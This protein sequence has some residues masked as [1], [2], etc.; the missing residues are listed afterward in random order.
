MRFCLRV[1]KLLH[2][3]FRRLE[4][5]LSGSV[6]SAVTAKLTKTVSRSPK[7]A[8]KRDAIIRAA[9]EIINEKSF[10]LATMT[11]IAGSLGMRDAAL[12]YYFSD[13]QTLVFACHIR[14][15][16]RFEALLDGVAQSS[17][18]GLAKLRRFIKRMLADS[19]KNG[20]QLYFGDH[21]YLDTAKRQAID[22]WAK[23]LTS[24]LEQFII[25]GIEDGSVVSCETAMVVQLLL[26]TLIWLAKWV[27]AD[28]TVDRL[29]TAILAFSFHGL[30]SRSEAR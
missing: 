21:S 13:K 18:T 24:G 26:G 20:P 22:T 29:M 15:L 17:G 28:M 23:R 5:A 27:P 4:M 3:R 25:D 9:I 6:P 10:A 19:A 8:R 11:D 30:E 2:K 1:D 14:S 12:Y 16:E 7:S